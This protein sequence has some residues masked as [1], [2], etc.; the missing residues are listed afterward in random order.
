MKKRLSIFLCVFAALFFGSCADLSVDEDVALKVRLPDDFGWQIYGEINNDVQMSQIIFDVRGKNKEYK[1]TDSTKKA[2]NNCVNVLNDTIFAKEIFKDYLQCPMDGWDKKGQCPG[3]YANNSNYNK[4]TVTS[5]TTTRPDTSITMIPDPDDPDAPLKPDT[6]ITLI[7]TVTLDSTLCNIDACWSKG[8][9]DVDSFLLDSLNK[10]LETSK[11]NLGVINAMCQLIPPS[12]AKNYLH[13]FKFNQTL[14][15]QHY[16]LFGRYDG[17]P[18][19]YCEDGHKGE[20]RNQEKHA[21]KRGNN[22][23]YGRY[24]F[25][26]NKTDQK[27]YVVVK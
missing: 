20:A 10:F 5:V 23:D 16:I 17:R 12:D 15:E 19:K 27:I 7:P 11:T 6:T 21:D 1:G 8:W 18:Y 13:N 4:L 3:I 24:A 2:V 26:L 25:C 9:D 14:V 22:Y